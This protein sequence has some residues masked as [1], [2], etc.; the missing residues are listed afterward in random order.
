MKGRG[1]DGVFD[2]PLRDNFRDFGNENVFTLELFF[3][4]LG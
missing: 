4:Q 1:M 2:S 3:V